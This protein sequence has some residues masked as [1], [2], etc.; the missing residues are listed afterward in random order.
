MNKCI[1]AL[2]VIIA[3]LSGCTT[4]PT[5]ISVR[6]KNG[7]SG[8]NGLATNLETGMDGLTSVLP[9]GQPF[10]LVYTYWS[11]GT[12]TNNYDWFQSVR[13]TEANRNALVVAIVGSC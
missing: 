2:A 9:N 4:K 10:H 6:C 13:N 7:I 5:V 12:V 1:T 8:T 3:L 11:D